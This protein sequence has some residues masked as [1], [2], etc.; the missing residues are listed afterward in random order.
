MI[1][2]D[3]ARE[4]PITESVDDMAVRLRAVSADRVR[5]HLALASLFA[6][7]IELRHEPSHPSDGPISGRLLA[8]VSRREV[9]AAGRA[10]PDLASNVEVTVEGDSLRVRS[11][12]TGTLSDGTKVDVQTNTVFVVAD[13]AIVGLYSDMDEASMA[14]WG[15]VLAAG[16]FEIP[17]DIL[18]TE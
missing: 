3:E 1:R 13:G 10:L 15:H 16:G 9:D 12:T 11:R 7:T 18:T 17:G 14:A 5:S 2:G 4:D 8:E 6:E